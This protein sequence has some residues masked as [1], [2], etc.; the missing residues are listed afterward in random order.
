METTSIQHVHLIPSVPLC[1]TAVT[2][3]MN[4]ASFVGKMSYV[5][6][7][8]NLCFTLNLPCLRISS[9]LCDEMRTVWGKLMF[10][11]D[12]RLH[13]DDEQLCYSTECSASTGKRKTPSRVTVTDNAVATGRE[14]TQI[15]PTVCN[16][17]TTI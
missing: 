11:C 2:S 14:K 7:S 16:K 4:A 1:A 5:Y 3:N 12:A 6:A 15:K 8:S 10:G 17:R 9:C 13:Q